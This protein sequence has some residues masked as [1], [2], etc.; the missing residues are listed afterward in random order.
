MNEVPQ[1][2]KY[3][4]GVQVLLMLLASFFVF[5]LIGAGLWIWSGWISNIGTI[6]LEHGYSLKIEED[7]DINLMLGTLRGPGVDSGRCSLGTLPGGNPPH[8]VAQKSK[9]GSMA[10][11]VSEEH[12]EQTLFYIDYRTGAYWFYGR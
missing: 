2:K 6:P 11:V 1:K 9:D 4:T 5:A 8:F 3:S 12:P 7:G 10:F